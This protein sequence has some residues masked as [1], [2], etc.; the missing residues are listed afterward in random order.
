MPPGR[1]FEGIDSEPVALLGFPVAEF[2]LLE[3]RERVP[4]HSFHGG[5]PAP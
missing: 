3:M 4:D 5:A 1:F 2:L